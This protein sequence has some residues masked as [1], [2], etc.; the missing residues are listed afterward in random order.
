MYMYVCEFV[1]TSD[2]LSQVL[3]HVIVLI[4]TCAVVSIQERYLV[5]EFNPVQVYK[6]GLQLPLISMTHSCRDKQEL[7]V[8]L[9]SDVTLSI[10][11][12][13]DGLMMWPQVTLN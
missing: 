5:K 8:T 7:I 10:C 13:Y 1:I 2:L 9:K 12:S 3:D 11:M 6:D 4:L